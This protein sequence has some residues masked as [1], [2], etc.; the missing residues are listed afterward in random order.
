MANWSKRRSFKAGNQGQRVTRTTNSKGT[1]TFSTSKKVGTTRTTT[2]FS[3]TGKIREYVTEHHPILGSRRTTRTINKKTKTVKPKKPRKTRVRKTR[4]RRSSS[5][6]SS[7][8]GYVTNSTTGCMV[9]L[10]FFGFIVALF[11]LA[12]ILV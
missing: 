6:G 12:T 10:L 3:S 9:P 1:S 7:S 8:S 5:K 2:S 4:V 11:P